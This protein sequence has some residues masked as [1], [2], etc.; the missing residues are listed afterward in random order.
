MR[1]GMNEVLFDTG[2]N[3]AAARSNRKAGIGSTR[4]REGSPIGS[5]TGLPFYEQKPL[6]FVF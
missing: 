2:F 3:D 4:W 6:A 5:K 1:K